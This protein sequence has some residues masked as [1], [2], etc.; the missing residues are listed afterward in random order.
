MRLK[1]LTVYRGDFIEQLRLKRGWIL[2]YSLQMKLK[3][4]HPKI[5]Q[6]RKITCIWNSRFPFEICT[7]WF[8]WN[9][10]CIQARI[11]LWKS[12]ACFAMLYISLCRDQKHSLV[13][14]VPRPILYFYACSFFSSN[15]CFNLSIFFHIIEMDFSFII[16]CKATEYRKN[17]SQF[18]FHF[19][20]KRW[21]KIFHLDL[22]K[23]GI[24]LF[25]I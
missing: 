20:K 25:R 22:K 1:T 17:I 6:S 7:A 21:K 23:K 12:N 2:L 19:I 14:W 11:L 18:H 5:L 9:W 10:N 13:K 24:D 8:T 4:P 15:R 16:T 3:F